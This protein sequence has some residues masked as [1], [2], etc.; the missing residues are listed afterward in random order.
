MDTLSP[1]NVSP[2]EQPILDMTDV[3]IS[4]LLDE[5]DQ[6]YKVEL[7]ST[8]GDGFRMEI[9]QIDDAAY[10]VIQNFRIERQK[11]IDRHNNTK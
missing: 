2:S 7:I 4:V 11:F 1:S 10:A 3:N 6:V 5:Q 8:L 9:E